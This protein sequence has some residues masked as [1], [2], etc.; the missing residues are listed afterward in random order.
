MLRLCF[1]PYKVTKS[2]LLQG[3]GTHDCVYGGKQDVGGTM[4]FYCKLGEKEGRD[5]SKV[6]K[7]AENKYKVQDWVIQTEGSCT[8]SSKKTSDLE[9][10]LL[11]SI[12]LCSKTTPSIA[13]I[14][15]VYSWIE[16]VRTYT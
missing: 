3:L 11:G 2:S 8:H 16:I 15:K 9:K 6:K 7:V 10:H 1:E 14:V 13:L 4:M 12:P 5:A